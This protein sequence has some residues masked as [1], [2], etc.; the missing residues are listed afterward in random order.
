MCVVLLC[1][2]RS[3]ERRPLEAVPPRRGRAATVSS[4]WSSSLPLT[5]SG[6]TET[7][8]KEKRST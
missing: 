2:V 1:D 3:G 8:K 7:N 5:P 6:T 4:G